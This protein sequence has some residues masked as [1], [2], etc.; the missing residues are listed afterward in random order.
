MNW[1]L[2]NPLP[3]LLLGTTTVVMLG[4][5]WWQS[6]HKVMLYAMLAAI[7][8]TVTAMI[9][10]RTVETAR[11]QVHK[12]LYDVAG[13]VERNDLQATMQHVHPTSANI[14]QRAESEMQR[15]TF[16]DVSI[17]HNLRIRTFTDEQPQRAVAEFN[18]LVIVSDRSATMQR[19][20]ALRFVR[21]TFLKEG[22]EWL[23][24]DYKHDPP[25]VAFE[26]RPQQ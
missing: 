14:R 19:Q 1:W 4:A 21:V 10:E 8:F 17:K 16:D 12:T 20:R 15:W 7:A 22:E 23:V 24:S 13:D 3:I 9:L 11:E 26:R 6:G 2:E 18:V 5:I 25:N